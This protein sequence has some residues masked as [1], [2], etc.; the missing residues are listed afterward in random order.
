MK[1]SG[2]FMIVLFGLLA[3][4]GALLSSCV[5]LE[6]VRVQMLDLNSR[7]NDYALVEQFID[8][9]IP[10]EQQSRLYVNAWVG[11][12]DESSSLMGLAKSHTVMIFPA[13]QHVLKVKGMNAKGEW[14]PYFSLGLELTVNFLHGHSYIAFSR[15]NYNST[16]VEIKDIEDYIN[17]NAY[18]EESWS[19]IRGKKQ[20]ETYEEANDFTRKSMEARII[21]TN[22]KLKALK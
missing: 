6:E 4:S 5:S 16:I 21:N 8:K 7:Y 19:K 3:T 18:T 10:Y 14:V 2:L 11:A 1:R 9:S 15:A 17:D 13:G 20:F 12:F 22:E